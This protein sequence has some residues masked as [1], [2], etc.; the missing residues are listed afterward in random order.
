MLFGGNVVRS[1]HSVIP[2]HLEPLLIISGHSDVISK[3]LKK[4]LISRFLVSEWFFRDKNVLIVISITYA[5]KWCVMWPS[6][7][8]DLEN[9]WFEHRLRNLII[10][11]GWM[12]S[13]SR[14]KYFWNQWNKCISLS[15]HI[16]RLFPIFLFRI[17]TVRDEKMLCAIT[18]DSSTD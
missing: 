7:Q 10:T 16:P 17:M 14:N 12:I 3:K 6:Y 13:R 9:D 1:D 15:Y 8:S 4:L 11:S 2:S 5:S 18:R